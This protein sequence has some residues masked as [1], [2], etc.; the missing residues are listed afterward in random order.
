MDVVSQAWHTYYSTVNF[1]HFLETTASTQATFED[2]NFL[3]QF[4]QGLNHT[5]SY[6]I[7][8]SKGADCWSHFLTC[9]KCMRDLTVDRMLQIQLLCKVS[10]SWIEV[11][12]LMLASTN[13][14]FAKLIIHFFLNSPCFLKNCCAAS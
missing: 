10:I 7:F 1:L 3:S 13:Y 9:N 5:H 4:G 8:F 2:K 12:A 11:F 6:S 14:Q